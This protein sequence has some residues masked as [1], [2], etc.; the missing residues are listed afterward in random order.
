M[1]ARPTRRG[2][3]LLIVLVA[4]MFATL[5]L[6]VFIERSTGD[7][8]IEARAATAQRLRTEAYSALETTLGVLAGFREAIGDLHSPLEGW[9]RPLDFSDYE[10]EAGR[11]VTVSFVDESGRMPLVN[12]SFEQLKTIFSAWGMTQYD[13]ERCADALLAW[14]KPDHVART[15]IGLES[16]EY[17]LAPIPYK[18]PGK[19]LRSWRELGAIATVRKYFFD[20]TGVPTEYFHRIQA[21]FSLLDYPEPNINAA[22]PEAFLS[23]NGLGTD[24]QRDRF[25]D[26]LA[27]RGAWTGRPSGYF[28]SVDQIASVL[29]QLPAGAKFG[30]T[31]RAL[32]VVVTVREGGQVYRLSALVSPPGGAAWPG[33]N[34]ST[35]SNLPF[36]VLEIAENDG[37]A[38]TDPVPP[39][40]PAK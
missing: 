36:A 21:A 16:Q 33:A 2:A 1:S 4:M 12:T 13:A 28:K 3:V 23:T 29:G 10:P 15:S 25:Q 32:R 17:E 11:R 9:S 5:A 7:L 22:V 31:V 30:V 39:K 14:M 6:T 38:S 37:P 35:S 18:A 8:L 26:Y 20:E 27:G 34:T 24:T 40:P 19:P